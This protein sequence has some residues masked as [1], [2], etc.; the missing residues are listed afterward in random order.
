MRYI[1]DRRKITTVTNFSNMVLFERQHII[2]FVN[3]PF[4][5]GKRPSVTQH[6]KKFTVYSS[7]ESATTARKLYKFVTQL[8]RSSFDCRTLPTLVGRLFC[9]RQCSFN[10]FS[11]IMIYDILL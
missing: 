6:L 9:C 3:H 10:H 4:W 2:Q 7:Y 11:K 1:S 5:S 8:Y